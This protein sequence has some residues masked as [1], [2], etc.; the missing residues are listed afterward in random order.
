MYKYPLWDW[1]T[2]WEIFTRES[3][4]ALKHEVLTV[5]HVYVSYLLAWESAT[6]YHKDELSCLYCSHYKV[7]L[8][9]NFPGDKHSNSGQCMSD[10]CE[11]SCTACKINTWAR[12][13]T[14]LDRQHDIFTSVCLSK[15]WPPQGSISEWTTYQP[16]IQTSSLRWQNGPMTT[17]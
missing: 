6:N 10:T 1:G 9:F 15:T 14:S 12:H 4:Q 11:V 17:V 16:I 5:T 8:L 13:T 7:G 2:P 3:F